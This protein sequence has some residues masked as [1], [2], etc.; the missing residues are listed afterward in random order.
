MN[1]IIGTFETI[2]VGDILQGLTDDI[3]GSYHS[4]VR[5]M[6]LR[7]ATKEEYLEGLPNPNSDSIRSA[8]SPG[9]KF[10]EISM[11]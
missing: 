6:I 4:G 8:N 11:D 7:E 1:R 10:Y 5:Y 2:R 9:A 3:D